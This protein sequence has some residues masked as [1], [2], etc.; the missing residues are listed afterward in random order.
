LGIHKILDTNTITKTICNGN[1]AREGADHLQPQAVQRIVGH[2]I[3]YQNTS[4]VHNS[5]AKIVPIT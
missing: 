3:G 1:K 2:Q 4:T 5:K